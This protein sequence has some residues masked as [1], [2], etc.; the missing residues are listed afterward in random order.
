MCGGD[1]LKNQVEAFEEMI[2]E[3]PFRYCVGESKISILNRGPKVEISQ[4][5]PPG[6]SG[7]L[8][9]SDLSISHSTQLNLVYIYVLV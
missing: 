2:S 9:I 4:E 1:R 8:L 3:I 6:F 7:T 5:H